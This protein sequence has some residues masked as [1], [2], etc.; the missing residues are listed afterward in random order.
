MRGNTQ[1]AAFG[2]LGLM[3]IGLSSCVHY[4]AHPLTPVQ[5]ENEFDQR[6]LA[7]PELASFV[8]SVNPQLGSEWPPKSLD[9][10]TATVIAAYFN[11]ALALA[12]AQLVTARAAVITA[13]GRPNPGF[14]AAGGYETFSSAP[15]VLRFELSLPIETARKRAYR[16]LEA[17]KL[18]DAAGMA[19]KEASWDVYRQMQAAWLDHVT[20][21][22]KADAVNRE[23]QI[24]AAVVSLMQQR[25]STGEISR[26]EWDDSCLE[27]SKTAV[28][29]RAAQ[30]QVLQTRIRLVS[31]IGL[32]ES[33][34]EH[35]K[36]VTS[37]H[38]SPEPLERLPL[39]RVQQKG[40]L[41]RLDIQRALLEYAAADAHLHL[42]IARQ[43]PDV[44][45]NPGYDFDEG[46]HKF[47]F[48]PTFPAPVWNR[49]RGP[50][51]EADAR[52]AEAEARFD[53]VQQNA[54]GQMQQAL[55]RYRTALAEYEEASARWSVIQQDRERSVVRAVQIGEQDQLALN[56]IKLQSLDALN[57]RVEATAKV[58]AAFLGLE[59]AVQA[60]L[61]DVPWVKSPAEHNVGG[62]EHR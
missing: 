53:V 43:Y 55:A 37:E 3:S 22:Q 15:V 42:E 40:L 54:I 45:L 27:A 14:A 49:N 12:R 4:A 61:E 35:V 2:V 7:D 50:I 36:L 20:A 39:A 9:L 8:R 33:A 47:T 17:E 58:R 29:L 51:A 48:G 10:K 52:R 6:S 11:P 21:V 26:P 1:F 18:A 62:A 56:A 25:L 5:A 34:L 60:P 38:E 57:A 23:S 44:Q 31:L 16:I 59:D 41:N 19:W 32:P 28:K 46:I 30:Q 13:G 24:R